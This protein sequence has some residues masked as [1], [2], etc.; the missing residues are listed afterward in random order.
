MFLKMI[1]DIFH[2]GDEIFWGNYCFSDTNAKHVIGSYGTAGYG[3]INFAS[4]ELVSTF[5]GLFLTD[6][7]ECIIDYYDAGFEF[8]YIL[9]TESNNIFF[10]ARGYNVNV[11]VGVNFSIQ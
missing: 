4:E 8:Q 2:I 6:T 7:Y 10:R 3:S 11:I 9:V 5:E 1:R